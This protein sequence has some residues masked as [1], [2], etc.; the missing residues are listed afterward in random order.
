MRLPSRRRSQRSRSGTAEPISMRAQPIEESV[1]TGRH[2]PRSMPPGGLPRAA[3]GPRRRRVGASF[4]LA[5]GS[6]I[7]PHSVQVQ[8]IHEA[9][10]R[11]HDGD[12]LGRAQRKLE[13]QARNESSKR[14]LEWFG[15]GLE[16]GQ[17]RGRTECAIA[18]DTKSPVTSSLVTL[19]WLWLLARAD[20]RRKLGR[21]KL[22]R[23]S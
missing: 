11:H 12:V 6:P 19:S 18:G 17:P 23:R 20:H 10:S 22:R 3:S 7:V 14:K 5:F 16:S 2:G 9:A 1:E 15:F 8:F 21:P 13:T 4:C